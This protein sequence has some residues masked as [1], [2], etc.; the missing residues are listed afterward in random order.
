[1]IK[2]EIKTNIKDDILFRKVPLFKKF[3]TIEFPI[4]TDINVYQKK[5]I[6]AAIL[7]NKN[8]SNKL[9]SLFINWEKIAKKK[10]VILGFKKQIK[11]PS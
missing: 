10:I 4:I 3:L 7:A 6:I 9:R 5:S 8:L 2:T 11:K 1:M